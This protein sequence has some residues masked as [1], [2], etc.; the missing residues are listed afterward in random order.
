M[1]YNH[2]TIND[3]GHLAV[4]GLDT[5]DLAS[6]YGTPL[7]VLDENVIRDRCRT[8]KKVLSRTFGEKALPLY[9]SKALSFTRLYQIMKEENMGVDCVS[10]GEI[11]TS[12]RA[13]FPAD[14]ICF[15]GNN[16]TKDDLEYA[17][18]SRIGTIVVDNEEELKML[19][20]LCQKHQ[21]RQKIYLRITPGIDPHTLKAIS[22]GNV[23]SK[24]GSA[25]KTGQ[26]LSIVKEALKMP[27]LDLSGLHCHIGSQIF[28]PAPFFDATRIMVDFLSEIRSACGV[29]LPE[30]NLGGGPGVPYVASDPVMDHGSFMDAIAKVL[31]EACKEKDFPCPFIRIEPGR[32]IVADAGLTLYTVG[33]VKTIPG[34]RTYV[35]VDGGMTDNPRYALYGS[36]YT[37]LIANR[38][39][40]AQTERVTIAGRCCESGD[41]IGENMPLQKACP[42]DI[43]AVLCTGAYNYSMASNYNRLPRA[44]IVMVRDGTATLAVRRETYEDL[45]RCDI[46]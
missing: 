32:S 42:G 24:F 23:D 26:A 17:L 9:A 16:K 46:P 6:E 31:N 1:L 27:C 21:V 28:D 25:I 4:G 19:N 40:D 43:L 20:D 35:S 41:L 11:Y 12:L 39:L 3:K 36:K 33:S 15:H 7:Y 38:A 2:L 29:V 45:V 44:P 8:Y 18:S 22:T 30:L 10:G 13:G 5:V 14:R 37:A 34:F